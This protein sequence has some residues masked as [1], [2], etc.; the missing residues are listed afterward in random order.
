MRR[1]RRR[2][3]AVAGLAILASPVSAQA[4]GA[5]PGLEGFTNGLLHPLFTPAH[6][7]MM[8][9]LGLLISQRQPL[10]VRTPLGVFIPVFA[11]ALLLTLHEAHREPAPWLVTGL[12]LVPAALV[13]LDRAIPPWA[14]RL[15]FGVCA[16]VLGLDSAVETGTTGLRLKTLAG[17]WLVVSFLMF[18]VASY[19]I[20][21]Q[22][23]NWTRIGVRVVASW[24]VA[25]CLLM[26]AF[27]LR[28]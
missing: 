25:I 23:R 26:L 8:L 10:D 21:A 14:M 9:A 4:H 12:V 27:A 11:G 19:A 28:R 16:V 3:G 7:L 2:I 6:V 24:M 17:N 18:D 5:I 15:L 22:R 13:A 1:G 20:H